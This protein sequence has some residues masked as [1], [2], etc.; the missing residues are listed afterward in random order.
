MKSHFGSKLDPNVLHLIFFSALENK[1]DQDEE[2][3]H[4]L[5]IR[6]HPKLVDQGLNELVEIL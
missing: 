6:D 4:A 1:L 5:G 3:F 2:R